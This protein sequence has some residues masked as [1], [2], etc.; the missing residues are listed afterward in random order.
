MRYQLEVFENGAWVLFGEPYDDE[1]AAFA[2]A[3]SLRLEDGS[4]VS[5]QTA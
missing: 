4:I 3:D 2:A 5:V 1:E